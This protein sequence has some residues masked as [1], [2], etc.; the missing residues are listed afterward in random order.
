M[1]LVPSLD[2][3]PGANKVNFSDLKRRCYVDLRLNWLVFLLSHLPASTQATMFLQSALWILYQIVGL[4]WTGILD[5]KYDSFD[6]AAYNYWIGGVSCAIIL[7]LIVYDS[8]T[9]TEYTAIEQTP[10]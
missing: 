1:P 10:P 7:G 8:M 6:V 9:Q 3:S 4:V 2:V 5:E